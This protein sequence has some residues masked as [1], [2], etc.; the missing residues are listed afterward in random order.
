MECQVPQIKKLADRIARDRPSRKH[1]NKT[2]K[3]ARTATDKLIRVLQRELLLDRSK[4][5]TSKNAL[6]PLVYYLANARS[7]NSAARLIQRF[8]L[9]SQ[10]SEHYG[11]AAE[12]TLRKDFQ[13]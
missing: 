3:L 8:F 6:V 5:F 9:L 2:W 10:L 13:P 4:Y 1:L 7:S 11:G 12:T